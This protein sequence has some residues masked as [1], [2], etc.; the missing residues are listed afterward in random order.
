MVLSIYGEVQNIDTPIGYQL[1]DARFRGTSR[2]HSSRLFFTAPQ[3]RDALKIEFHRRLN[4]PTTTVCC[5]MLL[6]SRGPAPNHFLSR[7][8]LLLIV[9]LMLLELT[10]HIGG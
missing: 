4:G 7:C 1:K 6:S 8:P 2:R 9:L 10:R 3:I 5:I